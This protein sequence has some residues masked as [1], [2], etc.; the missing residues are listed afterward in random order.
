MKTILYYFTGSGNSLAVA[1]RLAQG[2]GAAQLIPVSCVVAAPAV[3]ADADRIGIVF[4]VYMFGLPLIIARFL[5]QIRGAPDRYVFAVATYG[6]FAGSAL[7]QAAEILRARGGKLSAAFQVRMPDNYTPFF[8]PKPAARRQRIFAAADVRV[9][10]IA[11]A[12]VAGAVN[13]DGQSWF[14]SGIAAVIH[15]VCS[16]H[17]PA[18]DRHFRATAACTGCGACAL[19]CPVGNVGRTDDGRPVWRHHCEQCL[20]C[21]HWCPVAAIEWGSLTRGKRRYHH[22]EITLRDMV[23]AV[24]PL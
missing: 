13:R 5:R 8:K 12:V 24:A 16:P 19:V 9:G 7:R 1:R 6:G 20:A 21:L 14:I 3:V 23:E 22:P 15:R 11:R 17:I 10:R 18:M 2:I 4:P